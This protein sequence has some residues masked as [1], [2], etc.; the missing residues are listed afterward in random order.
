MLKTS[1]KSQ[2]GNTRRSS[3][4]AT[5]DFSTVDETFGTIPSDA[6]AGTGK[7]IVEQDVRVEDYPEDI[8]DIDILMTEAKPVSPPRRASHD[9]PK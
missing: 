2:S 3:N 5:A 8:F 4:A 7:A 6:S 9:K 1:R